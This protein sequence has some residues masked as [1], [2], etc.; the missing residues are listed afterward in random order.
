[1]NQFQLHVYIYILYINV[2]ENRSG[3]QEWKIQIYRNQWATDGE[4]TQT[5]QKSQDRKL[6]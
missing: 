6:K 5:K 1:M 4:R 2:R 3:N